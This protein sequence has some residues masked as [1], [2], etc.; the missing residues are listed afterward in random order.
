MEEQG[1]RNIIKSIGARRSLGQNFLV[2]SSIA[3]MESVYAKGMNVLELGPGLGILTIELCKTAKRVIAIEKDDRLFELLKD[4]LK[5]KKLRLINADFFDVDPKTLGK[6]DILVANIPYAL[7]SKT[8]YWLSKNNIP[9]L[10]C[11]QKEFAQHMLAKPG[12]RD[13][14]RLSVVSS[15][16]FKSH[17]V[18]DISRGN[19]YPVPNVD[20]CI[21]YLVPKPNKLDD[22]LIET[23]S[24]IMNHKKKRLKNALVDSAKGFGIT[25]DHAKT[26]S[27]SLDGDARPFQLDP[28]KILE[29]AKHINS[30]LDQKE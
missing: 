20:S 12:T 22:R 2:N 4:Q 5:S 28:D 17:R 21:L 16:K 9:A 13:Y 1:Y 19:F 6:I 26:L 30:I 27:E 18:K 23:I 14:S 24:L 29:I 3:A 10:I 8:I 15:L 11:V 7:S 25:K